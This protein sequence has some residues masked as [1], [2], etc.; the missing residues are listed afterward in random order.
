M[1]KAE[2][3]FPADKQISDDA[4]RAAVKAVV[5]R[6]L[7]IAAVSRTHLGVYLIEL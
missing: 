5:R 6:L 4:G 1:R 3:P 2:K 7:T